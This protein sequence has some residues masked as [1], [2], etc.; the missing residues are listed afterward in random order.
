[1]PSSSSPLIKIVVIGAPNVGKSA[2]VVRFL[3]R[4][5]IGEYVSGSEVSYE[6]EVNL[7]GNWVKAEI[8]DSLI[9]DDHDDN[10]VRKVI[11]KCDA[12]LLVYN[13]CDRYSF[14]YA[15]SVARKIR[16]PT[17]SNNTWSTP[18]LFAG[19]KTDLEH[20]RELKTSEGINF[21]D[22]MENCRH[23]ETSAAESYEASA[24]VFSQLFKLVQSSTE[25]AKNNNNKP[26]TKGHR[27]NRSF[28]QVA[29][30]IIQNYRKSQDNSSSVSTSTE[31]IDQQI[32]ATEKCETNPQQN[33]PRKNSI[34]G[35]LPSS[36]NLK[37]RK[38]NQSK[39]L[40]LESL[41][42]QNSPLPRAAIVHSRNK[43]E[44]VEMDSCTSEKSIDSF[45]SKDLVIAGEEEPLNPYEIMESVAGSMLSIK[46]RV[47]SS[48]LEDDL[49][50][51]ASSSSYRSR[52]RGQLNSTSSMGSDSGITEDITSHFDSSDSLAYLQ[53]K[54]TLE[55]SQSAPKTNKR[56]H[57][58]DLG[59]EDLITADPNDSSK[60][61][62]FRTSSTLPN[63]FRGGSFKGFDDRSSSRTK[64]QSF[65]SAV[66]DIIN[67]SRTGSVKRNKFR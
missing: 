37:S 17:K 24:K 14:E 63:S 44:P 29:T 64:K 28:S 22:S 61:I 1:M 6:H 46:Q 27:R 33:N 65:K 32:N 35:P 59:F 67:R 34:I 10:H 30:K 60:P 38:L 45:F 40:S 66:S 13:V 26:K 39:S 54:D 4:R 52:Q 19:N 43:S 25:A 48:S 18:I 11:S 23:T 16:Q 5:F 8:C 42:E 36:F 56:P 9:V 53:D 2:L 12:C 3:T 58:K 50:S 47:S 15:C 41:S 20:F 7:A 49:S 55:R 57:S 31:T 21:A 62:L 51:S